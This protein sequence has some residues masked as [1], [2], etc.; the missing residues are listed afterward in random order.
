MRTYLLQDWTTL[1]GSSSVISVKQ[2]E[3]SWLEVDGARDAQIWFQITEATTSATP[4]LY[5]E[6]SPT[7]DDELFLPMTQLLVSSMGAFVNVIRAR[8]AA[9]PLARYCRWTLGIANPST[10]TMT[11]RV[12]ASVNFVCPHFSVLQGGRPAQEIG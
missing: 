10:W 4:T 1:T 7:L 6:T 12:L 11:F 8:G 3:D 5:V 2:T 9:Q